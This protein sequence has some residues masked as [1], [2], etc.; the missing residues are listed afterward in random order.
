MSTPIDRCPEGL[1]P[2]SP[3][4]HRIALLRNAL[5]VMVEFTHEA[6]VNYLR[7]S[8]MALF[9]DGLDALREHVLTAADP[10]QLMRDEL[11]RLQADDRAWRVFNGAERTRE[12]T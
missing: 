1:D 10:R 4:A 3:Y 8:R 9:D 11:A 12:G 5:H 2:R 7:G 6:G